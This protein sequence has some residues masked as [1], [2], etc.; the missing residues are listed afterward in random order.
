[1]CFERNTSE[2]G[3]SGETMCVAFGVFSD[4][5]RTI[6]HG[7]DAAGFY[8]HCNSRESGDAMCSDTVMPVTANAIVQAA[9]LC[10]KSPFR[11]GFGH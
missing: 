9:A 1:M 3:L 6:K 4:P 11:A 8:V 5:S 10:L 7:A 2:E